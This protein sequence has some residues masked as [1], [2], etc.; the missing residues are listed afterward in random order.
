MDPGFYTGMPMGDYVGDPCPTP[1]VSRG[2]IQTLIERSPAHAWHE[3]PRLGGRRGG[4]S[5]RAD[6]GTAAHAALF[7]GADRIV[8]LDYPDYRTKAAKAARDSARAAG[9]TPVLAK[10][11][12]PLSRMA[13]VATERL[14]DLGVDHSS[15]PKHAE[16][17]M[18]WQ[19]GPHWCRSRFDY[20][21]GN[22]KR[23][24]E[25]KT[26]E[27]A[28]PA[29]W[30]RVMRSQGY[31]I[32]AAHGLRGISQIVGE[33][34][35]REWIWLVQEISAPYACSVIAMGPLSL[36]LAERKRLLGMRIWAECVEADRWPDYGDGIH[37]AEP[38]PHEEWLQDERETLHQ[39]RRRA[40]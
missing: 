38:P 1:S 18:L 22:R 28:S 26:A 12:G 40:S 6:L 37:Y 36:E 14:R 8:L 23:V 5:N 16:L 20:L 31:D 25:Y 13:K 39:A 10:L 33:D 4:D 30:E 32:Q 19:E 7:G 29:A 27:N 35:D 17:T 3:H 24:I 2:V 9:N 34:V 15:D 21:L 11:G